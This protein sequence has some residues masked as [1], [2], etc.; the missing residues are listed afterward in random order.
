MKAGRFAYIFLSAALCAAAPASAFGRDPIVLTPQSGWVANWGDDR[1]RLVRPFVDPDGQESV[2]YLEQTGP[3]DRFTLLFAGGVFQYFDE[4]RETQIAFGS[5][6]SQK[7]GFREGILGDYGDS[8]LYSGI[9]PD[10][11]AAQT[12]AATSVLVNSAGEATESAP[13]P[14]TPSDGLDANVG[15]QIETITIGDRRR[16]VVLETGTLG[17]VF[18]ALNDCSFDLLTETGITMEE[19]AAIAFSPMPNNLQNVATQIQRVYPFDALVREQEALFSVKLLIGAD[20]GVENCIMTSAVDNTNFD[21]RACDI[22]LTR[23]EFTPGTNAAG[24]PVR[25]LYFSSIRYQM[26]GQ[27]SPVVTRVP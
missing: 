14:F 22:F 11:P 1:C 10:Q 20:G 26:G 15:A 8:M 21:E 24:E 16:S 9:K 6:A 5:F 13:V 2:M 19:Y 7:R 27:T 23:G 25:S 3:S 17:P 18:A 12:L 4:D